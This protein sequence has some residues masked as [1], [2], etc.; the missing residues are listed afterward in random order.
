MYESF[1]SVV[2]L[3]EK[4]SPN[5][6]QFVTEMTPVLSENFRDFEIILV[7]NCVPSYDSAWLGELKQDVRS[8]VTVLNLTRAQ[9]FANALVAGLDHAGGDYTAI[10]RI[11]G[12]DSPELV[13][14]LFEKTQGRFDVV[15]AR[16]PNR[17]LSLL[18]RWLY[19]SFYFLLSRYSDIVVDMW[20]T[21]TKIISR[22]ALNAVLQ[23][24]ESL[25]YMRG[26]FAYIG[27]RTAYV[28]VDADSASVPR[29]SE[30]FREAVI[31]I[32]SFT[33]FVSRLMGWMTLLSFFISGAS[34]L[35]ALCYKFLGLGLLG[36]LVEDAPGWTYLVVLFSIAYSMICFMM[37]LLSLYLTAIISET[38]DRP[39]Y[40]VESIQH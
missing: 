29:T 30:I 4:H 7:N 23:L 31:A 21:E 33:D 13:V 14:T 6:T 24:R 8:H 26:I 5:A 36:N 32:T 11:D 15:I 2:G 35:N 1:V 37:Y 3:I 38:K 19:W 39:L 40:M 12:R 27:Y 25:R 16:C 18:K 34:I 28:D 22:R 17:Q 9:K 20:E 10:V